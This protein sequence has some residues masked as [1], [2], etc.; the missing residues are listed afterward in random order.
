MAESAGLDRAG[1][2]SASDHPP[3]IGAGAA[4]GPG[5]SVLRIEVAGRTIWQVIGAILLTLLLLRVAASA[6]G[7]L[8]MVGSQEP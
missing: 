2:P 6:S 1:I 8:S 3:P 7:L 4:A 5:R